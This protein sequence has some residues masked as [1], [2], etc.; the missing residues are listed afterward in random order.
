MRIVRADA[1]KES[2]H[3]ADATI[4]RDRD[5]SPTYR[6]PSSWTLWRR[7][8]TR[9]RVLSTDVEVHRNKE[10]IRMTR[11]P[12]HRDDGFFPLEAAERQEERRKIMRH[13]NA[14][15]FVAWPDG[16]NAGW[17]GSAP[18]IP[19]RGT[20]D[21]TS[22]LPDGR[23]AGRSGMARDIP[24][25]GNMVGNADRLDTRGAKRPM[26]GDPVSRM[27]VGE[28]AVLGPRAT[29]PRPVRR[30]TGGI[31]RAVRILVIA[32]A[33]PPGVAGGKFEADRGVTFSEAMEGCAGNPS[34]SAPIPRTGESR[35][36]TLP[37]PAR[38]FGG[39]MTNPRRRTGGATRRRG[40][41]VKSFPDK[42]MSGGFRPVSGG[43][44]RPLRPRPPVPAPGFGR[45]VF[46]A[47]EQ[48]R[49]ED[50]S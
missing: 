2:G 9:V 21:E 26:V 5:G 24:W 16:R 42:E 31:Q 12:D 27:T 33:G 32:T 14:V 7:R 20:L 25:R 45:S 17:P 1:E 10:E 29:E 34:T 39:S 40:A 18:C 28:F 48:G 15:G 50:A 37:S 47:C 8:R 36:R 49:L 35:G 3:S 30:F 46:R 11:S 4:R 22:S 6:E 41:V 19:R 38:I 43:F 23:K 44:T 13:G